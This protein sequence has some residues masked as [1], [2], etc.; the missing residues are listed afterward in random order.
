MS[1]IQW[2]IQGYTRRYTDLRKLIETS[3]PGC[4]CLQETMLGSKVPR[5]PAGYSIITHPS[6]ADP[7]P[8]M[9]LATLI[10]SSLPF[11]KLDLNTNI[12][13]LAVRVGLNKLVTVCNIY[14]SPRINHEEEEFIDLIE[15]L[16]PTYIVLGDFNAKSTLWGDTA[17][18]AKGRVIESL[19]QDETIS[20]MNTGEHTHIHTQTGTTHAIDLSL[21][22]S[23]LLLEYEWSTLGD[24][25]GSDHVVISIKNI[26]N[27]SLP[28]RTTHYNIKKADWKLFEELTTVNEPHPVTEINEMIEQFTEILYSAADRSIPKTNP[29]NRA[30]RVPWWNDECTILNNERKRA[31]RRYQRSRLPA[32]KLIYQRARAR[33]QYYKNQIKQESW[34]QYIS[35]ININTPMSKVWSKIRKMT[36]RYKSNH[37][38]CIETPNGII[39]DQ[40]QVAQILSEHFASV[41]SSQN[42]SD[43]FNR[44]RTRQERARINFNS[45]NNEEYNAPITM[46]ELLGALRSCTDSAPG[47]DLITYSMLKH[48]HHTCKQF[49]LQII[50]KIWTDGVFPNSWR[51]AIVLAFI[52][53][54][55]NPLLESSYRPIALTSCVCKLTEKIVNVRLVNTLENKNILSKYQYGF[56]K[57][58]STVDA[59]VRLQ[60][61]I[62]NSFNN[63]EYLVALF[64]DIQKAYDT[65]WRFGIM[66]TIYNSNIRGSLA[67]FIKNFLEMRTFKTRIGSELS[68]EAIQEQG[69]PQGSVLS[70]SLFLL[71]INDALSNLP[72]NIKASLYVD[73]LV[74]Y[75]S[76]SY[77]PSIERRLQ[78]AIN[79]VEQWAT[80]TGFKFS[81]QKSV[82]VQFHRKRGLQQE[83]MLTLYG[84]PIQ[85]QTSA[86]YLGL[87][88]DQRLRWKNHVECLRSKCLKAIDIL[89]CLA[90]TKWG[91]DKT[92]LLRLYRSLIRSKLDYASI[93]YQSAS[94]NIIKRL[95]PIHNLAIRICI[96][97]FKSSPVIS[98]Y[99]ES[100]EPSLY[101]RRQQLSLQYYTRSSQDPN[102]PSY[103][104]IHDLPE[105]P[106]QRKTNTFA[107]HTANIIETI[108]NPVFSVMT[109]RHAYKST[110]LLPTFICNDFNPPKKKTIL[111]QQMKILF[112]DHVHQ[113]HEQ[114]KC[115]YTDGSKNI[116][117]VGYA[118]VYDNDTISKKINPNGSIFTAEL[119]A[120]QDA[121]SLC[122]DNNQLNNFVIFTDS[123]SA[124][125]SLET[126]NPS[127]P[128]V[129]KILSLLLDATNQ[130]KKI[131]ICWVPAHSGIVGNES[132]DREAVAITLSDNPIEITDIPFRDHFPTI[133]KSIKTIWQAKWAQTRNNKLREIK[134]NVT[135]WAPAQ[136][137]N[138]YHEVILTRLRI[139]HTLLTHGHLMERRPQPYCPDCL[140]PLT[141]KHFIAECPSY[142]DLLHQHFPSTVNVIDC[143]ERLRIALADNNFTIAPLIN[144]LTTINRLSH[145]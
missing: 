92:M 47:A 2:N 1:I 98:L 132:A 85:F 80:N 56:R 22:S 87:I 23:E 45:R 142:R 83:P 38:P 67:I 141:V 77:I 128:I 138:R 28:E 118:I 3:S 114:S 104:Y 84:N 13:A 91:S 134:E 55:K 57:Q 36:G 24:F 27:N 44:H 144:Y 68:Q 17:T 108:G 140:V 49:L 136:H 10:N 69:V 11:I 54:G 97:A 113:F 29:I 75:T 94:N 120:I 105:N 15:Q 72:N 9:G 115:I 71:A 63:K 107:E 41:S 30:K 129:C 52:K 35:T 21:C 116:N 7:I 82:A 12:Q 95:D 125:Q 33:A 34:K 121:V 26:E 39:S 76:S 25:Y 5:P 78:T 131:H 16:P 122:I 66:K 46:N 32:D 48:M 110:W 31:L 6:E 4:I 139:G 62:L 70:C 14:I 109:N 145:L 8:G 74:I 100:G 88:W 130:Q 137:L 111:P 124:K 60:T 64:F 106:A 19:L 93:I 50:N 18:D 58:R 133:K 65:A 90:R 126:F 127:H 99:S 51:M 123:R 59:L 117:S 143:T 119:L 53:P 42:Y 37:P 61:D 40:Q 73:D 79:R 20:L 89:K 96:G 103:D 102:H 112:E 43:N 86:K 135:P 101:Y 81:P